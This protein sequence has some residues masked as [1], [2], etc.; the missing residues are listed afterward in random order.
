MDWKGRSKKQSGLFSDNFSEFVL[1]LLLLLLL[2]LTAI[3]FSL[4]GSADK[5]SKKTYT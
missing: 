3:E 5:T 2:L 1:L 4:G